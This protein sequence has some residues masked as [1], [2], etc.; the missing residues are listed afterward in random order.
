MRIGRIIISLVFMAVI[1]S[2]AAYAAEANFTASLLTA[3]N[4]DCKKC[5][6]DTPHN[7]H[8]KKPVECVNC[9]G[10]KL[11]VSIPKCT[12]CHDGPIHQVHAGKVATQTC[13]YCHKDITGVHNN[14]INDAVCSHCHQDLID[15]HGKE[16]ACV[17][18]HK[19]PPGIVKPLKLEGMVLICQ[20][21]HGAASVATIHGAV[22][23]KKGCYACHKGTS[24]ANGS[25]VPHI[26]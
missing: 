22:D 24:Q 16:A 5:H 17:K 23:E 12:K 10:D 2:T 11:D 26:I 14:L 4:V 9:H 19:T 6:N 15:V 1:F 7:I 25:D 13:A 20:D 18:C 21:C 3:D 8:A